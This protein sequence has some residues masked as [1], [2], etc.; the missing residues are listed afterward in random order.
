METFLFNFSLFFLLVVRIDG[1]ITSKISWLNNKFE[2]EFFFF[3]FFL[4][5]KMS[6]NCLHQKNKNH[7][8][9]LTFFFLEKI[10]E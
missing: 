9:A 1:L 2:F 10:I 4:I 6:S 7:I 3:F 8:N 5:S